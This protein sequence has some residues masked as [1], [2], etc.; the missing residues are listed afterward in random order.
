MSHSIS[1]EV[2][3]GTYCPTTRARERLEAED[4][5]TSQELARICGCRSWR[6]AHPD[7]PTQLPRLCCC[8]CGEVVPPGRVS[9]FVDRNHRTRA[10][11]A[12][13]VKPESDNLPGPP[14]VSKVKPIRVGTWHGERVIVMLSPSKSKKGEA[15]YQ[16]R[17]KAG[18]LVLVKGSEIRAGLSLVCRKC[19]IERADS[20]REKEQQAL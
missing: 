19:Q 10:W 14:R 18:H 15:L 3:A 9:A 5:I 7:E 13:I 20:G 8:G 17:C 6:D 4:E 11:R 12:A 1:C 2:Q 16:L